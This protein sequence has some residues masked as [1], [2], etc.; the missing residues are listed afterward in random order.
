MGSII[1]NFKALTMEFTI[2]NKIVLLVAPYLWEETELS[3]SKGKSPKGL[4]L[5][6]LDNV[7]DTVMEPLK[8]EVEGLLDS[9]VDIFA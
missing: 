1:C 2:A 7:E 6:L 4:L 3:I 9:F 5:Q 8:V